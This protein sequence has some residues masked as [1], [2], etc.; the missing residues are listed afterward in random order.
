MLLYGE[1]SNLSSQCSEK[2]KW[3]PSVLRFEGLK[4]T[5][6]WRSHLPVLWELDGC[7]GWYPPLVASRHLDSW[8][9]SAAPELAVLRPPTP[10]IAEWVCS[11]LI[12]EMRSLSCSM[13]PFCDSFH[14]NFFGCL[15]RSS[16]MEPFKMS[17]RSVLFRKRNWELI[18]QSLVALSPRCAVVPWGVCLTGLY[19]PGAFVEEVIDDFADYSFIS[20]F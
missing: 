14:P 18:F 7:E 3:T 10:K 19:T 11:H 9:S 2:G 12:C 15:L 4:N 16:T 6:L 20:L 17:T 13:V 1:K 8:V 5:L